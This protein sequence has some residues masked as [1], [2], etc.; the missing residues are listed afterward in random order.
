VQDGS[1]IWER[2]EL[3]KASENKA[4]DGSYVWEVWRHYM[5]SSDKL[6]SWRSWS[7]QSGLPLDCGTWASGHH[8]GVGHF[9]NERRDGTLSK[10]QKCKSID[11]SQNFWLHRLEEEDGDK[12]GPTGTLWGNHSGWV[13]LRREQLENKPHE[14]LSHGEKSENKHSCQKRNGST[15]VGHSGRIA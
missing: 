8:G 1:Y 14:K 7:K 3:R 4:G 13:A 11:H 15:P 10:I 5:K 9:Q 6:P 2:G 12:T